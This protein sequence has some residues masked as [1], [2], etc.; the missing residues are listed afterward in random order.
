MLKIVIQGNLYH[1][2]MVS[3]KPVRENIQIPVREQKIMGAL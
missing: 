3:A 2:V 1:L